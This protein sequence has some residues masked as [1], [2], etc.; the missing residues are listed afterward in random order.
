VPPLHVQRDAE[1]F[2]KEL[3]DQLKKTSKL[4]GD[5]DKTLAE[6]V[7]KGLGQG[8]GAAA[9]TILGSSS[10]TTAVGTKRSGLQTDAQLTRRR[11]ELEARR[12]QLKELEE[13]GQAAPEKVEAGANAVPEK[14]EAGAK[15]GPEKVEAGANAV[16]EKVEAGANA[17]PEKVEAAKPAS[18]QQGLEAGGK[19]APGKVLTAEER[20]KESRELDAAEAEMQVEF[21]E[22][23]LG[24]TK[25]QVTGKSL[26]QRQRA[27]ARAK[28][29]LAV[30]DQRKAEKMTPE[31]REA[32][33]RVQDREADLKEEQEER[34]KE[35]E[36]RQEKRKALRKARNLNRAGPGGLGKGGKQTMGQ[37]LGGRKF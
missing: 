34:K 33:L 8:G 1:G 15:A 9:T 21:D 20:L 28:R 25:E 13:G 12:K 36:L 5:D 22:A 4:V 6:L 19:G 18:E 24:I 17:V 16:P 27:V 14:V 35:A 32:E 11:A 10:A 37:L 23:E 7:I 30:E 2:V 31:E 26:E 3:R 29:R